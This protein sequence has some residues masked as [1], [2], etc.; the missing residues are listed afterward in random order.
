V[1]TGANAGAGFEATW[2]FLSKGAKVVM[3]NRSPEK[4]A[5]AVEALKQEFGT[6]AEVSFVRRWHDEKGALFLNVRSRF[7]C[8]GATYIF[9]LL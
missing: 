8:D 4:S 1:I 7:V 6:D 2:V 3:L 5:S 9:T